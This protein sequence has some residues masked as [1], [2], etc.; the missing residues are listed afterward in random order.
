VSVLK[1]LRV[2]VSLEDYFTF[3]S[4]PGLDPEIG[5]Q[6]NDG[7]GIDRGTYPIPGRIIFGAST[8]F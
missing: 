8:N 5:S 3:T 7:I 2:F 4:Y 6:F 1:N